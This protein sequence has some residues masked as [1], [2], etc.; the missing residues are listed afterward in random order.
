MY[1]SDR[2]LK[3]TKRIGNRNALFSVNIGGSKRFVV[4][5]Y[6]SDSSLKSHK[7]VANL[8]LFVAVNVALHKGV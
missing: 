3:N 6:F 5:C 1:L 4:K 8:D 2:I 7:S